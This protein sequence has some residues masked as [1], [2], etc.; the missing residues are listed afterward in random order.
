MGRTLI[1][2]LFGA[3]AI[4]PVHPEATAQPAESRPAASSSFC[5]AATAAS[6][7]AVA[8]PN[9]VPKWRLHDVAR[10]ERRIT[11]VRRAVNA[12]PYDLVF[13][14]DSITEQ[15]DAA[16]WRAHF[17]NG[18]ALNLGV[19]YDRTENVLWRLRE[20]L[21]PATPPHTVVILI[22]TNDLGAKR[23]PPDVALGVAEVVRAVRAHA[24]DARILLLS[25]L[26]RNGVELRAIA[27]TNAAFAGCADGVRVDYL[28]VSSRF[29]KADGKLRDEA[30]Q[31]DRLHLSAKGYELLSS[32]I[33]AKLNEAGRRH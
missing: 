12:V 14:G 24:P 1:A 5:P 3:A 8:S 15:W 22:G 18:R 20:G 21:F 30:Y 4:L 29:L 9:S 26:P 23:S 11:D 25:I 10:W 2:L 32:A 31:A 17:G 27:A 19:G 28:D 16:V 7:S 6:A 13:V 33:N